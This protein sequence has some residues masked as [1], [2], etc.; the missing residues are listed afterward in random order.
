MWIRDVGYIYVKL[1]CVPSRFYCP[2]KRLQPRADDALTGGEKKSIW[3]E[4]RWLSK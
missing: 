2:I 1:N 3:R 4:W